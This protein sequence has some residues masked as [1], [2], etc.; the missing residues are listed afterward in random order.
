MPYNCRL[1]ELIVH[2]TVDAVFLIKALV[3]FGYKYS[4]DK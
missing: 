2:S 3:L 1:L 4:F